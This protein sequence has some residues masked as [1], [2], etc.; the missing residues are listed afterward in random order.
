MLNGV[1]VV[2]PCLNEAK[3]LPTCLKQAHEVLRPLGR[4]Y[5]IIVAD[6]GSQDGSREIALELGARVVD[7]KVS[8]YGAAVWTGLC[9]ARYD[10]AVMLDCD[11]SYPVAEIPALV[12]EVDRGFDLVL[13]NRLGEGLEPGAMPSLHRHLGTPVLSGL[14]RL[15]TRLPVYDSNSGLRAMSMTKFRQ[16]RPTSTGM[17]FASEM[18]VIAGKQ[19]VRYKEIPIRFYKDGRGRKSHLRPW[20]DGIRHVRKI[21]SSYWMTT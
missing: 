8:G 6:N 14:I 9:S 10:I 5:E 20:P 7:V 2:F 19:Q 18:L 4:E 21:L 3:T 17:E 15:L 1:S 13:G 16:M 11:L 12:A